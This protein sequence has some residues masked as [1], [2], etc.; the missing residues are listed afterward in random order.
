[1]KKM[2]LA[3]GSL[4][5]LA[6][7]QTSCQAPAPPAPKSEPIAVGSQATARQSKPAKPTSQPAAPRKAVVRQAPLAS[8]GFTRFTEKPHRR[9][10][11]YGRHRWVLV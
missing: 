10:V 6:L 5:G 3:A 7:A 1:M 8:L 2:L 11:K 4:L 9:K